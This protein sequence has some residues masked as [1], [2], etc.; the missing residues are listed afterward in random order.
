MRTC[1]APTYQSIKIDPP[2]PPRARWGAAKRPSAA[3][4]GVSGVT[5]TACLPLSWTRFTNSRISYSVLASPSP[6]V[7]EEVIGHGR[8]VV[9][10]GSRGWRDA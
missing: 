8:W 1:R 9:R 6:T 7:S 4:S 3:V 5:K 10:V 2:H